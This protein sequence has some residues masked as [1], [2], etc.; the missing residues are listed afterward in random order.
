MIIQVKYGETVQPPQGY[1]DRTW[2]E[3]KKVNGELV[4]VDPS[5]P[6]VDFET[7][8]ITKESYFALHKQFSVIWMDKEEEYCDPNNAENPGSNTRFRIK[9]YGIDG[10][11][12]LSLP[13]TSEDGRTYTIRM[14]G[15][16]SIYCYLYRENT[17]GFT[18]DGQIDRV[19]LIDDESAFFFN[20]YNS[21]GTGG[22]ERL[23]TF[24]TNNNNRFT[25]VRLLIDTDEDNSLLFHIPKDLTNI[26]ERTNGELYVFNKSIRIPYNGYG[27]LTELISFPVNFESDYFFTLPK[28]TCITFEKGKENPQYYD[29]ENNTFEI[30]GLSGNIDY[31]ETNL[32]YTLSYMV[33]KNDT[34]DYKFYSIS[35]S[36]GYVRRNN[37]YPNCA[38]LTFV[39]EYKVKNRIYY[40]DG[41]YNNKNYDDNWRINN[42]DTYKYHSWFETC[43]SKIL[44]DDSVEVTLS[45]SKLIA[46]PSNDFD[47][48]VEFPLRLELVAEDYM[49][50]DRSYN[51]YRQR[52]TINKFTFN[53]IV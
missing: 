35:L 42:S 2:Y 45:D 41:F 20:K 33:K 43:S 11:G 8:S 36:D 26:S 6:I 51:I 13:S 47:Y 24:E 18:V 21:W 37:T 39:Q 25:H 50:G 3:L 46:Y 31:G 38:Q 44:V 22:S 16:C 28:I 17:N 34:C 29:I 5:K 30:D 7:H 40:G 49:W 23:V 9:M 19:S 15:P 32:S 1:E 48:E 14:G 10:S 12:Y 27:G 53:K 52:G 4:P